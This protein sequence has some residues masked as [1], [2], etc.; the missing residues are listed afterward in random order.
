MSSKSTKKETFIRWMVLKKNII[1]FPRFILF[2]V[3]LLSSDYLY[4]KSDFCYLDS[5]TCQNDIPFLSD[6]VCDSMNVRLS[7]E[8][9]S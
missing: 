5:I 4:G 6:N 9:F 3:D 1:L 8:V 7:V 2:V